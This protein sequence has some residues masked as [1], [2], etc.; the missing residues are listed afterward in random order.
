MYTASL[1]FGI[2]LITTATGLWDAILRSRIQTIAAFAVV[3]ALSFIDAELAVYPASLLVLTLPFLLKIGQK[4]WRAVPALL[5]AGLLGWRLC[6]M[7]PLFFDLEL[8]S[9]IPAA[10]LAVLMCR[11]LGARA[12][13][14]CLSPLIGQAA[15]SLADFSLFGYAPL[16]IGSGAV[17]GAQAIGL[18]AVF[19]FTAVETRLLALRND[20]QRRLAAN[21]K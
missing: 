9:A 3:F 15:L 5:I 13:V 19:V 11:T 12:L 16:K 21:E 1:F 7:Y 8:L 10:L 18:T 2:L 20:R 6:D 14:V 4:W 17:S